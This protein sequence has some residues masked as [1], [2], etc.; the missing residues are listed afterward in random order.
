[1]KILIFILTYFMLLKLFLEPLFPFF[2]SILIYIILRPFILYLSYKLHIK[3]KIIGFTMLFSF[4]A[5]VIMIMIYV[6]VYS[7]LFICAYLNDYPL[8][9]AWFVDLYHYIPELHNMISYI[10]NSILNV[11]SRFIAVIPSL[12]F[13]GIIMCL[14]AF[15]LMFEQDYIKGIVLYFTDLKTYNI[16]KSFILICNET[17]LNYCKIQIGIMV[18]TFLILWIF[19]LALHIDNALL[20]SILFSVLDCFPFLGIGVGLFPLFIYFLYKRLYLKCIYIFLIFIFLT[21]TRSVVET[22]MMNTKMKIPSFI[23][24]LSMIIHIYVYGIAGVILSIIHM[25][26][27]FGYLEYRKSISEMV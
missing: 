16:I 18:F 1:M 6:I 15:Y 11:F 9:I 21:F 19:F 10:S 8:D 12:F 3:S 26:V 27:A 13:F 23:I 25:N 5:F 14:S 17:I 22:N 20:F 4:F 2:V 24:L 7:Y